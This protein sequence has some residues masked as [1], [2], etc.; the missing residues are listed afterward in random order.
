MN[1]AAHAPHVHLLSLD[2]IYTPVVAAGLER[3]HYYYN[4]PDVSADQ[5][6]HDHHHGCPAYKNSDYHYEHGPGADNSEEV[7]N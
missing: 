6:G 3:N 1:E 2:P 5:G 7:S 4:I